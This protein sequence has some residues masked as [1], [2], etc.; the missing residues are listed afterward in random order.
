MSRLGYD[1][2]EASSKSASVKT[3]HLK[4]KIVNLKLFQ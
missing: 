3:K 2:K 4:D 1:D